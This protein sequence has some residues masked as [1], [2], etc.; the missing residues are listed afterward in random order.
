M[1]AFTNYIAQPSTF[2]KREVHNEIGYLDKS[3]CYTFDYDFWM[4]LMEICRPYCV[5]IPLSAFRIHS[6]SK[7]GSEYE[8]QFREELEVLQRYNKNQALI[9]S[10]KLHNLLIVAAYKVLK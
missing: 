4:R 7:G 9:R 2:W 1:L 5:E 8:S 6:A 3:L 10:H